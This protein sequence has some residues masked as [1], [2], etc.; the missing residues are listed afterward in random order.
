MQKFLPKVEYSLTSSE[1]LRP[2]L[3]NMSNGELAT[4]MSLEN[5]S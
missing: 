5:N 2:V 1:K 3:E 4:L